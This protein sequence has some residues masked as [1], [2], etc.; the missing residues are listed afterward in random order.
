MY[1]IFF[2]DKFQIWASQYK[3]LHEETRQPLAMSITHLTTFIFYHLVEKSVRNDVQLF[4]NF[5]IPST[6]N[7][8]GG[9][10]L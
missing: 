5:F 1:A 6:L 8:M 9:N 10:W 4:I 2:H 7:S 3:V